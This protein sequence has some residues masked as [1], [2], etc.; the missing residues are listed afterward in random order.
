[1]AKESLPEQRT[2]LPTERRLRTRLD[3]LGLVARSA[4]GDGPALLL[5]GEAL[6]AGGAAW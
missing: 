3:L 6:A 1:M 5:I 4:L 2:E